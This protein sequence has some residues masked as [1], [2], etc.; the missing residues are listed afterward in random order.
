MIGAIAQDIIG[1]RFEGDPAPPVDFA[2][3]HADCRF[4]DDSACALAVA[5]AL[6]RKCDFALTLRE[7]VAEASHGVPMPIAERARGRLTP[8]LAGVQRRFDEATSAS[9]S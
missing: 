5:E 2:L 6:L 7:F 1:S 8:D 4:T 3:F 9:R